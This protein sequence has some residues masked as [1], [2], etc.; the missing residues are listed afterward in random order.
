[1]LELLDWS[2][3]VDG[4]ADEFLVSAKAGLDPADARMLAFEREHFRASIATYCP[5]GFARVDR[6]RRCIAACEENDR[7]HDTERCYER[8]FIN[9][10][11]RDT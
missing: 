1:M 7:K 8:L 9:Q 11:P 6:S 2:L 3:A 5:S 4:I 10:E